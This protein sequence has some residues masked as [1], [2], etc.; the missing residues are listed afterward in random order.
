MPVY[1]HIY[2]RHSDLDSDRDSYR[3]GGRH[4]SGN[5]YANGNGERYCHC[6]GYSYSD[7]DRHRWFK[8]DAYTNACCRSSSSLQF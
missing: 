8:P 7:G 3:Y 1:L 5:G 2:Y 6:N 4:P